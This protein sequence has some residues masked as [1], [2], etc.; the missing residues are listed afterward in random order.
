MSQPDGNAGSRIFACQHVGVSGTTRI[1][2]RQI[3]KPKD[4]HGKSIPGIWEARMGI[5]IMGYAAPTTTMESDPFER[6]FRDNFAQGYGT[7]E[8]EAIL[9][10]KADLHETA[11]SLWD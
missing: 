10:L 7:S 11:N 9:A 2:V 1:H 6:T 8:E 5:A 4:H 3:Q